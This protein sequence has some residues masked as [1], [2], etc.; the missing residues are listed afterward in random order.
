M[1]SIFACFWQPLF[2]GTSNS[3]GTGLRELTL[4]V[5]EPHGRH[6]GRRGGGA[7]RFRQGSVR[8]SRSRS[9]K[10]LGEEN[11]GASRR[12]A[13]QLEIALLLSLAEWGTRTMM[14][15]QGVA[16]S[17]SVLGLGRQMGHWAGR[18]WMVGCDIHLCA[19]FFRR[20][21][22]KFPP[23][24]RHETKTCSS[25]FHLSH[26]FSGH[27]ADNGLHPGPRLDT[28]DTLPVMTGRTPQPRELALGEGSC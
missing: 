7:I 1:V 12:V 13:R 10:L 21:R 24:T 3:Q 6:L 28:N 25:S 14:V 8:S 15:E 26:S 9:R 16:C 4:G 5:G 11:Q 23:S 20:A 19:A 27:C 17:M 22:E 18:H 2:G